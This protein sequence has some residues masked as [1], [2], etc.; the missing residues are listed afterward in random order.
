MHSAKTGARIYTFPLDIGTVAQFTGKPHLSEVFYKFVS[1]LTPGVIYRC[2]L[3]ST[4]PKP[5]LYRRTEVKDY[6]SSKFDTRQVFYSSKDGTRVPMYII[7]RK[8]MQLNGQ[9]PCVLYGYGG[10]NVAIMPS[11]GVARLMFIQHFGG[12]LAIANIRGGSEYGEKWHQGAMKEKKQNVF[13]DFIAGAE[14]LIGNKYTSTER[15]AIQGGSNGGLL[16]AAC[17]NQRPDLFGC[18]L[19]DVGVLDMLRY[20]N[21]TI[22]HAWVPEFGCSSESHDFGYLIKYSPIHNLT[23]PAAGY[24][25][26]LL[27]TADHDDRVVPLHSLKYIAQLYHLINKHPGRQRKPILIRIETKAGHGAGKPTS[28]MID[29]LTDV[30]SFVA[31]VLGL[32]WST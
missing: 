15:L 28:K 26:M 31:R 24:P 9:N 1:F 16:V 17:A 13:D 8:D 21:F 22:G 27:L 11:F 32:K 25:A 30:Y 10:F 3:S 4:K 7:H 23:M 29:E 19:M 12:I 18:V 5:E 14:Y 20:Q 2:D 6:D